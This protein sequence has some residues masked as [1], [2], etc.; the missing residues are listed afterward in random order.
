[1]APTGRP[2]HNKEEGVS[3]DKYVTGGEETGNRMLER[4]MKE[5]KELKDDIND[6]K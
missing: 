5:I 3:M 6:K 4:I 1:M 2:T